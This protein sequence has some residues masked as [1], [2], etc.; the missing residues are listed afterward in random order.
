MT[1]NKYDAAGNQIL[2]QTM[3]TSPPIRDT[4]QNEYDASNQLVK[5]TEREG[6]AT[7]EIINSSE[8]TYNSEGQRISKTDNGVTTN[9]YYQGG[10]LIYT[11]DAD[12]NKTSQNIVGLEGNIIATIRYDNGQHAYF[13]N[14]DIR[15]SVT[16]VVD[17][18]FLHRR[19]IP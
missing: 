10:V 4:V 8:Y 1:S 5:T 15:T 6:G 16:N 19:G 2:E 12:G 9:Y 17:I 14:K 7:G 11:T 3:I 13:Y 18:I